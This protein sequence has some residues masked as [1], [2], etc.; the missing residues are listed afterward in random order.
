LNKV[1]EEKSATPAQISLAWMIKKHHN[2][3][4]IPASR[5]VERIA[6]NIGALKVQL[7]DEDVAR[8]D[9]E[10]EKLTLY[11]DRAPEDEKIKML[12]IG[13]NIKGMKA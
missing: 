8:I 6:E 9:A 3:V 5:K 4:P 1:S 13:R 12:I 10:L 7:T 11:G 2:I